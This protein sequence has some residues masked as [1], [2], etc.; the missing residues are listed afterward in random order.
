MITAPCQS[1]KVQSIHFQQPKKFG[2]KTTAALQSC[3]CCSSIHMNAV[4]P[5]YRLKLFW[6]IPKQEKENTAPIG[7]HPTYPHSH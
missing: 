4:L 5:V 1:L 2:S 3:K 6:F 7:K